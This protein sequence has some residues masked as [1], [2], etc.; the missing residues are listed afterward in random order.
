MYGDEDERSHV[1]F[2]IRSMYVI[3]ILCIKLLTS[4]VLSRHVSAIMQELDHVPAGMYI[5]IRDFCRDFPT[6]PLFMI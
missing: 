6:V 3:I 1:E 2:S 4:Y 5:H